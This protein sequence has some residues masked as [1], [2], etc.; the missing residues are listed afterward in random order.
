MISIPL[1]S[2]SLDMERQGSQIEA[3][4]RAGTKLEQRDI[5]FAYSENAP[6]LL[7][8]L[9]SSLL[10]S[11][12][13]T[14]NLVSV[15]QRN[16]RIL[17]SFHTFDRPMG[18]AVNDNGIAVGTRNQIWFLRSAPDI[19]SKLEPHGEYDASFL[20]RY[21]H[22]TGDLRCHDIAWV[23][24]ELWIVNTL[25]SCLCSLHPSYNF[26][27]RWRPPFVSA[28]VPEDR[29]H[30]NG[31]AIADGQPRYV[32]AMAETD[33]R[34]GWRAVK[35]TGGCLIDVAS[36]TTIVRGLTMPHSPR[37][38]KGK[39]YL[40][41]SGLG[42]LEM[43]NPANGK[44]DIICQLPGYARGLAIS[45]SLA[46]VGLSKIRVTSEWADVPIVAQPDRLKCGVWV[47]DLNKGTI[48]CTFE[49]SSG[50][51]EL[52]DVQLMPGVTFPFLSGPLEEHPL[53][54]VMPTH[55]DDTQRIELDTRAREQNS[56]R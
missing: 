55:R 40:L 17:P 36:G 49:F 50:V 11:T 39:L 54:T 25:F 27:P 15:S 53:W 32:S 41:H 21:A 43:V 52:F 28:L 29:C 7:A 26:A 51:D 24:K 45:G 56:V 12:Y 20:A 18:V 31:L 9:K 23:G 1:A 13:L 34:H 47:V 30:L 4:P 8:E 10:I 38:S 5:H 48:V 14:G 22:F 6:S 37:L 42:Q 35:T 44:R 16:G 3:A 33:S 46:F 19:A 2:G